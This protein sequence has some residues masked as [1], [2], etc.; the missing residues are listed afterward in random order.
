[1][2][3][4]FSLYDSI[5]DSIDRGAVIDRTLEG[6]RWS[7][8]AGGGN[9]GIAMYTEGDSI[10]PM[11]PNGLAGMDV[12]DAAAA[13]KSWNM[14]EASLALAAANLW[15]NSKERMDV[16]GCYEPYEN[17][18]TAGLDVKGKTIAA[19]GHLN[20]TE[21]IHREA[22]K[23]YIIERTPQCGDYPDT[24]CDYLLPQCDIVFITGSA[25]INKSLPHLLELCRN[26]CTI[27][28]GPS[29]PMCPQLLEHGI[30]RLAGLVITDAAAMAKK[31][32][33]NERGNPYPLGRSW[34]LRK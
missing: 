24:A 28:T 33:N 5:I 11:F 1:M 15:Y 32:R 8:C 12:K 10:S 6:E 31:V 30:D 18:C 19:V 4:F 16:L 26:A 3:N 14:H 23:V 25:I 9:L 29:V 7:A 34:L 27:L 21:E 13:V 17:Y 2:D 20:M 22:K